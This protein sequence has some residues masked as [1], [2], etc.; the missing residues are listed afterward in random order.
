MSA[1]VLI[2][3][4]MCLQRG[5]LH[6]KRPKLNNGIQNKLLKPV[7]FIDMHYTAICI[8]TA[9]TRIQL[10]RVVDCQSLSQRLLT[11]SVRLPVFRVVTVAKTVYKWPAEFI[12]YECHHHASY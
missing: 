8:C 3:A 5:L 10:P 4:E 6:G 9:S 2:V 11:V 7:F 12:T 1:D